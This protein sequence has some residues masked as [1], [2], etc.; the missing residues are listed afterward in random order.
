MKTANSSS[1]AHDSTCSSQTVLSEHFEA[2]LELGR[3][4]TKELG[5]DQSVDT[6][7]RWMAHYIADLIQDAE[8]ANNDEKPAKMQACCN[9]IL[10]I[11]R[12]RHTLP[13]G[14]RPFEELEP[15]LRSLESL[16]PE[17][18]HPRYFRL[19]SPTS[20][21]DDKEV[22]TKFWLDFAH[23]LDFSAKVLIRF[24]LYQAMQN[25]VEKST[26]WAVFAEAIGEDE[27][28]ELSVL[29]AIDERHLYDTSSNNELLKRTLD[30]RIDRL[31]EFAQTANKLV[32]DLRNSL[33]S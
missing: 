30:S 28:I 18:N 27:G 9:A 16:D 10:S 29:R 6:L 24:C 4:L 12:H 33:P 5:L 17:N 23:D 7:G 1:Q 14:K 31:E 26:E 25:A 8:K 13:N 2:T 20:E 3:K 22:G 21:D 19:S 11:W 32:M 15:I